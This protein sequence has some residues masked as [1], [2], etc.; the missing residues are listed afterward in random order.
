MPGSVLDAGRTEMN[1]T[2]FLPPRSSQAT[3]GDRQRN[4]HTTAWRVC[5]P[6]HAVPRG[7]RAERQSLPRESPGRQSA[8]TLHTEL[9]AVTQRREA[10]T[11]AEYRDGRGHGAGEW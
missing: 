6:L 8:Q 11:G 7:H 2:W 10:T 5:R 4:D 9:R 3:E 1:E